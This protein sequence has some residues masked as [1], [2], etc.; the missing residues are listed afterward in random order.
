MIATVLPLKRASPVTSAGSSARRTVAVELDEVV[1]QPLDVVERVRALR[2]TGELDEAPG[3]LGRLSL[4]PVE[5]LLEPVEV[6]A[7]PRTAQERQTA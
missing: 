3:L 6:A 5:L 1:E 2:V 4:D 7:Q